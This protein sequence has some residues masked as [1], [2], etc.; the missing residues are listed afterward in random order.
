MILNWVSFDLAA[1]DYRYKEKTLSGP[2]DSPLSADKITDLDFVLP[3]FIPG[4]RSISV[5]FPNNELT[6]S[7]HLE[8]SMMKTN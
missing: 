2:L 8:K 3:N 6:Q 1:S 7:V 5:R 4:N